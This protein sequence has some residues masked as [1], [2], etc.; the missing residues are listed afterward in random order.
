MYWLNIPT[1]V[2]V[3][4]KKDSISSCRDNDWQS[5]KESK[6]SAGHQENFMWLPSCRDIASPKLLWDLEMGQGRD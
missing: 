6:N 1:A 4:R 2:M 3:Q 5:P